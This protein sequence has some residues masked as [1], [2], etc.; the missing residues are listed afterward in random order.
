MAAD[1]SWDDAAAVA[2]FRAA[3]ATGA[4]R[5]APIF[6]DDATVQRHLRARK[7]DVPA[8]LAMLLEHQAWRKVETPWWPLTAAPVAS[9]HEDFAC[10]KAYHDGEDAEG[11]PITWVRAA[12]HDKNEDRAQFKRFLSFL[13]DES[14]ARMERREPKGQGMNIVVDFTGFGYSAGFDVNAGM[15]IVQ[16]LSAHFP[17]RLR[18]IFMTVGFSA[19]PPPPTPIAH[20]LLA[21]PP[22]IPPSRR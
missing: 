2:A 1:P 20:H 21:P 13:S 10:L 9:I 12:L 22:P 4:T 8:A 19:P 6:L 16:T 17:E 5:L 18:R 15:L 3:E 14:V 11:G 7:G